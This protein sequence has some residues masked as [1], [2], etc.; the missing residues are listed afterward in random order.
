[1]Y[2]FLDDWGDIEKHG[3][4]LPHWQQ[5]EV[6]Q[7]V[8]FRLGDALPENK[9]K[10][11]R[12]KLELWR[13]QHPEPWGKQ[14]W[15]D[16]HRRF[17]ARFEYWLDQGYGSCLFREKQ[18]RDILR[19]VF[20]HDHGERTSF[21]AWVIMPNHVHLLFTPH[22]SLPRLIAAWKSI[23]ARKLGRGSI[24]QSN[25]RDTLIR[26]WDHFSNAMQYIRENPKNLPD[27]SFTL[28]EE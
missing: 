9:L 21:H 16:Y 1:M 22:H 2:H 14:V 28:W 19:D 15:Q 10:A 6:M 18:N 17:T 8:T 7:F 27:G 13:K 12:K 26:D 3:A 20:L 24:W 4:Q 25:Y 11:W 5:G 23:S